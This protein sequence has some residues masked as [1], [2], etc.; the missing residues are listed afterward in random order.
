MKLLNRTISNYLLYSGLL[1]LFCTPLFYF[2]IQQLFVA[3]MD[4]VLREHKIDFVQSMT[5]LKTEEDLKFYHLMNQEFHVT[6]TKEFISSD[7]LYTELAYDSGEAEMVPHRVLRTGI[8]LNGNPFELKISESLVSNAGLIAT[9]MS[10][11]IILLALLLGGTVI[12]NRKLSTAVWSPFYTILDRLKKYQIDKD[13]ELNLP[14]SSTAE[15]RDLSA[16][17]TQLVQ[18]NHEAYLNQKEFTE[19]ASHELQTPIAIIQSKLDLLAQSKG[20]TAEQ[21]D[22]ISSLMETTYRISRLNKNL[23]LLAKIEN[24]QFL[25]N[26]AV[27]ADQLINKLIGMH[28][29]TAE[30]KKL[31]IQFSHSGNT[32]IRANPI[33]LEALINNLLSNAIRY[34][35][36][37]QTIDLVL[38][39]HRLEI[40]N[41]GKPLESPHKIFER[42]HRESRAYNGSGLGL[43]IAKKI[44]DISG[45]FIEYRFD[46]ERH[47]F[48]IT[49]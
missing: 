2:T 46:N 14:H 19:N 20:L 13:I 22:L 31:R 4:E 10:A 7:S 12:I 17:V 30:E 37:N 32:I 28:G 47:R 11:E 33:L 43:A 25:E 8:V 9:I 18:K 24:G 23:L 1:V 42:F 44:C 35:H 49:F 39:D 45:Y 48:I 5:Y 36:E 27:Q 34:T 40:V 41:P 38:K 21:A 3:E 15:F 6:P 16:A 29:E 26:E